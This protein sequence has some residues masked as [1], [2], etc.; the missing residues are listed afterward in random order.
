MGPKH[1]SK[2][3]REQLIRQHSKARLI[4]NCRGECGHEDEHE[5]DAAI[6]RQVRRLTA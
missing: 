1:F 4:V 6:E 3:W 5:T 2:A